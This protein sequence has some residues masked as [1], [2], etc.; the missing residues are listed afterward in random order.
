MMYEE[1]IQNKKFRVVMWSVVGL[2][3]LIVVFAAGEFIGT[4]KTQFAYHW[5]QHYFQNFVGKMP[6]GNPVYIRQG[7]MAF[8]RNFMDAHGT[9]GSVIRIDGNTVI[10]KGS[11]GVEKNVLV[12]A[13][14]II[15]KGPNDAV[16][17]DLKTNDNI[18]VIGA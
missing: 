9:M 8:D 16:I 10:I 13:G 17:A 18:I 7:P 2:L 15:K 6:A 4:E 12:T 3:V 11:D 5:D 1:L 14:T